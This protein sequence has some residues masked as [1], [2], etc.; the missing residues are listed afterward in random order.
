[1]TNSP[2]CTKLARA[3]VG[4]YRRALAAAAAATAAVLAFGG[5][6]AGAAGAKSET[7]RFYQV[8]GPTQF[9]NA[10]GHPINLNPPAT[11]PKSGDR[12]DET[13]LD[14]AGTA[15]HHSSHWTASDHFTCTFINADTGECDYQIAIGGSLLLG[16]DF[17]LHFTK[18]EAVAP[19]SEG[20]G[21]FHGVHGTLTD[22]DLPDSNNAILT[23]HLS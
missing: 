12:F 7:L 4:R 21:A 1:M 6:F 10:S 8:G 23:F 22:V 15:R 17:T 19:V 11:L 18:P 13:D 5:L 20:T 2:G 14:Y 3:G 16:N 9:Y